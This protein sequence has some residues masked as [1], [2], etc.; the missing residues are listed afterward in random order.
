MRKFLLTAALVALIAVPVLAQR[1]PGFGMMGPGMLLRNSGVQKEIKLTDDQKKELKKALAAGAEDMKKAREAFQD[2]DRE[3]GQKFMKKA[4]EANEKA[5]AKF[6][7]GLKEPQ[8]KR[9]NQIEL[10]TAGIRGLAKEDVQKKLKLTDKQKEDIKESVKEVSDDAQELFRGI[11]RDFK[12]IPEVMKKV[13]KLNKDATAKI[14]KGF[15]D[16]QKK[17]WKELTGEPYELKME[18][19]R[20]GGGKGKKKKERDDL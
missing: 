9:L 16:D 14:V 8:L 5:V 17:T 4:N 18:F 12:K 2:G 15:S 10:Q 7:K 6:K 1:R 20:P 19:G 13:T 3:E 11:G